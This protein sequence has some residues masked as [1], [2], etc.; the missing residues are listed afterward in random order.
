MSIVNLNDYR[1][2][3]NLDV[4]ASDD[5]AKF[6]VDTVADQWAND[7]VHMAMVEFQKRT[8]VDLSDPVY[9]KLMNAMA[10]IARSM[11]RHH[12]NVI[13]VTSMMLQ[14]YPDAEVSVGVIQPM[15]ENN[16]E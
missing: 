14:K 8:N 12:L 2:A 4:P 10:D 15:E 7:M 16:I 6:A 3:T 11:T 1:P 13:D 9:G 5:C